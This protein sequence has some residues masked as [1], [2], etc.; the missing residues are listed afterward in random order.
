MDD[1]GLI[2]SRI[3]LNLDTA[4]PRAILPSMINWQPFG[5][6]STHPASAIAK[7]LMML[8]QRM[9]LS[10]VFNSFQE[11]E[12]RHQQEETSRKEPTLVKN[13]KEQLVV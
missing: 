6:L 13:P 12:E 10:T 4:E 8:N 11:K 7:K 9:A 3:G 5:I 1:S 2:T